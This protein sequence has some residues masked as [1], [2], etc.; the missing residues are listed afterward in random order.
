ARSRRPTSRRHARSSAGTSSGLITQVTSSKRPT[1]SAT[2][3]AAR[4][5]EAVMIAM[6]REDPMSTHTMPSAEI[7]F[8]TLFAYQRS[9]A[10]KTAIDLERFTAID[11]GI[12]TAAALAKRCR[13]S[14]RGTRMLC[15]Y[16][17][18]I[19]LLSKSGGAY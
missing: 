2:S 19:G 5:A 18:T 9:A 11:E 8:D 14:E 17:V 6:L 3:P 10:L 7:V 13:A 4:R 1:I 16:L 15:D 12:E